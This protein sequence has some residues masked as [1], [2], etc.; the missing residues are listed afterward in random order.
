MN[1]SK[2]FAVL[3]KVNPRI[4]WTLKRSFSKKIGKKTELTHYPLARRWIL[5]NRLWAHFHP[6]TYEYLVN[7][8]MSVLVLRAYTF[9]KKCITRSPRCPPWPLGSVSNHFAE[10][11]WRIFSKFFWT[12]WS[13]RDQILSVDN[14]SRPS[15]VI[16]NNRHILIDDKSVFYHLHYSFFKG[17]GQNILRVSISLI[18]LMLLFL[19][20]LCSKISP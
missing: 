6:I 10:I 19:S 16:W 5:L 14:S 17:K 12:L 8:S 15:T 4:L 7:L 13:V 3:K 1:P 2:S 11:L 9:K 18:F 20:K